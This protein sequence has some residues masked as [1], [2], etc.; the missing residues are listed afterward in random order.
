MI[1]TKF[2]AM[3]TQISLLQGNIDAY[4]IAKLPIARIKKIMKGDEDVRMISLEAPFL[5]A[6]ACELFIIEMT[7]KAYYYA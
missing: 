7:N 4:K 5:F 1:N 2:L 3:K 6:K